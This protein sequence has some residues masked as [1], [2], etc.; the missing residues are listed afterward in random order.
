L[1]HLFFSQLFAAK[2]LEVILNILAL[3]PV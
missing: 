3:S 1:C 2:S